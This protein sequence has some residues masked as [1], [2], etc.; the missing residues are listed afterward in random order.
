VAKE[1]DT[2]AGVVEG[3]K[4]N[5]E[6]VKSPPEQ[7]KAEETPPGVEEGEKLKEPPGDA[8]EAEKAEETPPGVEEGEKLKEPPGDAEEA[9]KAEPS[10]QVIGVSKKK[11]LK[12][13]LHIYSSQ[14]NTILHVTD[15]TGAET[16]SIRTA[17]S[18]VKADKDKSTPYAAMLAAS[19]TIGDI[20]DRGVNQ[21]NVRIRAP[22]GQN[23]PM[24]PG[25]GV[26]A[27]IKAIS[28]SGVE[29]GQIEDVTPVPH[30]GCRPKGGKRG[31]R[32]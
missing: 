2:N 22:G 21:L 23:G 10:A 16:I 17:G 31:R 3:E 15:I 13:V 1:E 32:V 28:R 20:R 29:I 26:A 9:E 27:A 6:E 18:M 4:E 14:N 8:E 19:R 30:G 12:G 11:G 24:Y 7:A 5:E 25:K